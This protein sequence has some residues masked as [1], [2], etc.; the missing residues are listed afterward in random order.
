MGA[1]EG[2]KVYWCQ[3][4]DCPWY[5]CIRCAVPLQLVQCRQ[6]LVCHRHFPHPRLVPDDPEIADFMD[7]H[8]YSNHW[9]FKEVCMGLTLM[10]FPLTRDE[11][12]GQEIMMVHRCCACHREYDLVDCAKP[13]CHHRACPHHIRR[14]FDDFFIC[15]CC[16]LTSSCDEV[17][18]FSP[19]DVLRVR[20]APRYVM[21][22]WEREQVAR[23]RDVLMTF[24]Y[25]QSGLSAYVRP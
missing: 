3:V 21:D 15:F 4:K 1:P 9:S 20:P 14:L 13:D 8:A 25:E 2:L 11:A 24:G 10:Y 12:M 5:T 17:H 18:P 7:T 6:G 23:V 19:R 22:R 16:D